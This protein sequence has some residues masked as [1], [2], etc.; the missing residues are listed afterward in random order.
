MWKAYNFRALKI[1]NY[2][3]IYFYL[4]DYMFTSN[5]LKLILSLIKRQNKQC[6]FNTMQILTKQWNTQAEMSEQY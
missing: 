1:C 6:E 5:C 3:T 4:T 2:K